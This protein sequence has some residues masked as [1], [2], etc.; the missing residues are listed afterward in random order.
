[1]RDKSFG[2]VHIDFN[3]DIAA[4]N[5]LLTLLDSLQVDYK[6]AQACLEIEKTETQIV[7][8][9]KSNTHKVVS[10]HSEVKAVISAQVTLSSKQKVA[11]GNS[12]TVAEVLYAIL[13]CSNKNAQTRFFSVIYSI[14]EEFL[15]T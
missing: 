3:N 6:N 4:T 8:G 2:A 13:Q 10:N 7:V 9:S 11:S 1:M 14:W 15:F 5:T 12:T